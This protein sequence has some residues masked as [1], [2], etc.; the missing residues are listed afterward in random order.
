[1]FIISNK[2]FNEINKFHLLVHLPNIKIILNLLRKKYIIL[3]YG[4]Y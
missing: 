4:E 1:M 3:I 2:P